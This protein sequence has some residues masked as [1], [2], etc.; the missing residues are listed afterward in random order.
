M[1]RYDCV[2]LKRVT[3]NDILEKNLGTLRCDV[4]RAAPDPSTV[5]GME[6]PEDCMGYRPVSSKGNNDT[7]S[8]F[9]AIKEAFLSLIGKH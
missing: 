8:A 6:C 5:A 3:N 1:I 2:H 7:T 4:N 9:K